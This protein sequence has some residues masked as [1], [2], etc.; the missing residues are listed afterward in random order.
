MSDRERE[1]SH[2]A[3][4]K[5]YFCGGDNEIILHKRLGDVSMYHQKVVNMN[6]CNK[7]VEYMKQG[8]I[9]IEIDEK[10]SAQGWNKESM[11]N[12]Y[13]SGEFAVIKEEAFKRI[14]V[15]EG[16]EKILKFA[17]E[18]RWM[19]MEGEAMR[20]VGIIRGEGEANV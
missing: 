11:P 4:T 14:V 1:K 19:F 3:L 10:K 9:L 18:N 16:S 6:P 8:I 13:R 7:C 20:M 17:L 5:C 15:G 2:V 12:P